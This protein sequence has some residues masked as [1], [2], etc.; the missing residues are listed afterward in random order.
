MELP[1]L[2]FRDSR[3]QRQECLKLNV[4]TGAGGIAKYGFDTSHERSIRCSRIEYVATGVSASCDVFF[5][6]GGDKFWANPQ[7]EGWSR[8]FSLRDRWSPDKQETFG[9]QSGMVGRPC[10]NGGSGDPCHN[11]GDDATTSWGDHAVTAV[12]P[13][14]CIRKKTC[15]GG[16]GHLNCKSW[17]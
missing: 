3:G 14:K 12:L 15:V 4:R 9:R 5:G 11:G 7:R 1:A 2:R 8:Q 16:G 17:R 13:R 6:G 10:H